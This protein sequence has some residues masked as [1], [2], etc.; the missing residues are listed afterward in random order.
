MKMECYYYY[1]RA[2]K[3]AA[4]PPSNIR[5]KAA[6]KLA[7]TVQ[8]SY[9]HAVKLQCCTKIGKREKIILFRSLWADRFLSCALWCVQLYIHVHQ[10]VTH[11]PSYKMLLNYY[12][13][14]RPFQRFC[15]V[16]K[17]NACFQICF[18]K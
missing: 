2:G 8:S 6:A 17:L 16:S 10:K 7:I 18:V 12:K 5:L 14:D 1:Y 15:T 4:K 3:N 11:I 13:I 9:S